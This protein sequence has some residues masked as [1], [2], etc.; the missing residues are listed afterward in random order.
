MNISVD[1]VFDN[2]PYAIIRQCHLLKLCYL[3]LCCF[4][5]RFLVRSFQGCYFTLL[6]NVKEGVEKCYILLHRVGMWFM[7]VACAP[8]LFQKNEKK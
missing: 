4:V 3:E 7:Y 5:Y 1:N 8:P 2:L 6:Y